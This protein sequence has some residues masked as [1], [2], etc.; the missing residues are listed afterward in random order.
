VA[1]CR[2][3]GLDHVSLAR[4]EELPF[5]ASSFDLLLACDVIEHVPDD[6]R[7]L[8]ELRRVAAPG[9]R[10]LLTVPAYRWLWSSHDVYMHHHRRYTLGQLRERTRAA[11]WEPM[12]DSYFMTAVLPAVA[13]TRLAGKMLDREPESDI[14]PTQPTLNRLLEMVVRAEAA[15]IARGARLPAG[16]SVGMVCR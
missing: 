4:V 12:V 7:A 10:L 5:E 8:V 3:R 9:A 11:G 1:F 13:V 6:A 16:V 2:R 14:K 15:A